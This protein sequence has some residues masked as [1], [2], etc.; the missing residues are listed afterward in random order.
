M[1]TWVCPSPLWDLEQPS[2]VLDVSIQWAVE[3][4]SFVLDCFA[5]RAGTLAAGKATFAASCTSA[6]LN[7]QLNY[8]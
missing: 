4:V 7:G 1:N 3:D 6:R 5:L 2:V 8:N